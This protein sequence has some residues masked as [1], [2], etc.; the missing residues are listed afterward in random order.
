MGSDAPALLILLLLSRGC[1]VFWPNPRGSTG[2]GPRVC[3]ARAG[4]H[5]RTETQDHLSGLDYLVARGFA[6]P[7]R[8][9]VVGGSHGGF[10]TSWLVTQDARFAAAVSVA[11]V[12]NH[13]T[14]HLISNIPQFMALFVGDSYTNPDGGYFQRS[15]VMYAHRVCTPTLNICGALD[16]CTPP[17]KRSSSTMPWWR[18]DANR[19]W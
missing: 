19:R 4:R 13:V 1:S 6:D 8:I 16:R 7:R 14:Q 5:G 9:G 17:R 10:M 12:T 2:R 3:T 18:A 11:P 15:P